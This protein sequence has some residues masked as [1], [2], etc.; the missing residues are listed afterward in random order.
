MYDVGD[1]DQSQ[2]TDDTHYNLQRQHAVK[3]IERAWC[4]FRDKRMFRVLKR[5]ICS[6]ENSVTNEVLK[7]LSP[8]EA[9][10]LNDPTIQAK[11]RFRFGGEEFPPVVMFKVF[12]RVGSSSTKYMSGKKM[13]RA[14]SEAAQD[15][16]KLMGNRRYYDQ[17]IMDAAQQSRFNITDV[18]DVSTLRDYMMLQSHEDE[19]PSYMGGRHNH[20]RELTLETL[21]RK[22]IL[23][24]IIDYINT[25]RRSEKLRGHYPTLPLNVVPISQPAQYECLKRLSKLK[26]SAGP[27]SGRQSEQA[28]RRAAKMRRMYQ[29]EEEYT[30][31]SGV[32]TTYFTK[33]Q[34]GPSYYPE[35]NITD[36]EG[37]QEWENEASQL[38]EWSQELSVNDVDYVF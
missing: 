26:A 15:A 37:D 11:V 29:H 32:N 3:L 8:N 4:S 12:M 5:S 36:T 13:I 35:L 16:L 30:S 24:D 38:Y 2:I 34:S 31:N 23:Y 27:R 22:D 19:M 25:G 1:D 21:S 17:L 28:K 20:W 14:D 7:K 18:M 33:D 10:V 6:A 9:A